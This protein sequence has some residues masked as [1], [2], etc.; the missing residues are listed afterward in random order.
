[1]S[2]NRTQMRF[3]LT[4]AWVIIMA[5]TSGCDAPIAGPPKSTANIPAVTTTPTS[6]LTPEVDMAHAKEL[7][8]SGGELTFDEV[9]ALKLDI[10]GDYDDVRKI[11]DIDKNYEAQ[12]AYYKRV[13]DFSAQLEKCTLREAYGWVAGVYNDIDEHQN[14][15]PDKVRLGLY[16]SDPFHGVGKEA[17]GYPD[18]YLVSLIYDQ[19][20]DYKLGQRLRFSG[21]PLLAGHIDINVS[22]HLSHDQWSVKNATYTLLED[23]PPVPTPTSDQLTDLQL[24]LQRGG[25][26]GRCPAYVLH[27]EPDGKVTFEGQGN[28]A[29]TGTIK[30]TIGQ[31]KLIALAI[32]INKA[33]FFDLDH[34]YESG[35]SDVPEYI[36]TVQM[37]GVKRQ[38]RTT[39]EEGPRRFQM[40]MSRIDGI[41]NSDQWIYGDK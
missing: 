1:M 9:V 5:V 15:I 13:E 26:F 28:T 6:V 12:D 19:I 17:T 4:T 23:D 25:C 20:P 16:M 8:E 11:K 27:I 18:L 3:L 39:S 14:Q 38:V 22:T 33:T 10:V 7:F 35:I 2:K 36:L 29:I 34:D 31:D 40:L 21:N 30:S 24:T 41:V 37:G 32:E